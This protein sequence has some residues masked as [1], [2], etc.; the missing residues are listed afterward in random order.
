MTSISQKTLK[1]DNY[2]AITQMGLQNKH[3]IIAR[4][5]AT[6]GYTIIADRIANRDMRYVIT[7]GQGGAR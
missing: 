5:L 6:A 3:A 1:R 4:A 2:P 7:A